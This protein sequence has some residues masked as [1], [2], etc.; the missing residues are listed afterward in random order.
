MKRNSL[1]IVLLV[2]MQ[3][4]ALAQVKPKLYTLASPFERYTY[5]LA[6]FR[7]TGAIPVGDFA[8][9]YIDAPS[10]RNFSASMEWVM[11]NRISIG[12]EIGSSYF[13]KRI[14]RTQ[15]ESNAG[16]VSAVQTRTLSQYPIQVFANYHFQDKNARIQP[17]IQLSGGI[18]MLDY[19]VY[20][21]SLAEQ[22]QKIKPT[23]GIGIGSKFIFK[24]DGAW[25]AD[26]RLKYQGT[27]VKYDYI[28]NSASSLNASIGIFY[29]WW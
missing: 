13:D 7:Y 9:S 6:T 5:Y 15:Y 22:Y 2:L 18:S 27:S 23:Y 11:P 25:G 16:T 1:L 12:G 24:Q 3:I 8:S 20:Y 19:T 14:A 17:Y 29:R 21:G 10:F 4:A 28:K 26:I